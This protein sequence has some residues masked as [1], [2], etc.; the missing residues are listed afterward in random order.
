[1]GSSERVISGQLIGRCF[2]LLGALELL[3]LVGQHPQHANDSPPEL[4]FGFSRDSRLR[5]TNSYASSSQEIFKLFDGPLLVR[6]FFIMNSLPR[7][8]PVIFVDNM[9]NT[10]TMEEI[11][12]EGDNR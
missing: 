11:G 1:M 9:N 3:L 8:H 12:G 4:F 2:L 10:L 5:T 6:E 7:R